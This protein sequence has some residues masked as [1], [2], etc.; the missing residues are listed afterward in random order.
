MN[1]PRHEFRRVIFG[2]GSIDRLPGDLQDAGYSRAFF[3]TTRGRAA[4]THAIAAKLGE[5]L[6]GIYSE[7][8]EHVPVGTTD[9]AEAE[10]RKANADVIVAVGGGSPIG[11]GKAL[12]LRT[13]L[14]LVAVPTTYSGS[15][16]TSIYGETD[17]AGKKT[18]KDVRVAPKTIIYDPNLTLDLPVEVS[19]TS[20]I[21]ALAHSV[22][23]LYAPNATTTSDQ[24]A[25]QS[26]RLLCSS[27]PRIVE[28]PSNPVARND[29]LHGAQLAGEA[30]NATA[31]G[32][33]HRMCHVLG[34]SFAMPHA[35]THSVMLRYVV[36]FNF[37]SARD[38]MIRV[39]KALNNKD[40]ITGID[41]FCMQL[42]LP[43]TLAEL[44]FGEGQVE[45]AAAEIA[46]GSYPNPRAVTANSVEKILRT[47]L[48]G[49][50]PMGLRD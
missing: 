28:C 44:G 24:R 8:V 30:L 39:A 50:P 42:P 36:A 48:S 12:V 19:V 25:E 15:E 40:A 38:A 47:A 21:N 33:H 31:M 7:A 1:T 41:D 16:M 14:P 23:S 45:K 22:E 3:V 34:G 26:I 20:G 32:L 46:A 13:G 29:A 49:D 17:S 35:K 10:L 37:N 43:R 5:T 9:K 27:L 11:L 18:G 4:M 2:E 6:A